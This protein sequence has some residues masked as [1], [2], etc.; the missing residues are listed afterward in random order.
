MSH[1]HHDNS[2]FSC[3]IKDQKF[4]VILLLFNLP[5]ALV[6]EDEI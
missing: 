3:Y 1:I 2:T 6:N 5:Y 4:S